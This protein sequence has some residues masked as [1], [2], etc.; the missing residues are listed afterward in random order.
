MGRGGR[1][2]ARE[3]IESGRVLY[4][5]RQDFDMQGQPLGEIHVMTRSFPRC[6][7]TASDFLNCHRR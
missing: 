2:E 3:Q 4:V 6:D 5:P 1:E 7:S